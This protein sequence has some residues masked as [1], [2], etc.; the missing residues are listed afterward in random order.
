MASL[1][2]GQSVPGRARK[3]LAALSAATML[4]A[5]CTAGPRSATVSNTRS[6][7]A[8]GS[9]S[10]ATSASTASAAADF[11]LREIDAATLRLL[12]PFPPDG[13]LS[14][15]LEGS[16]GECETRL[17][18]IT[19]PDQP[20]L[21]FVQV[22]ADCDPP[23]A[24]PLNGDYGQFQNVADIPDA[25]IGETFATAIGDAT[26]ATYDYT[27][28]TNSC[29]TGRI[30]VALIEL[31]SPP[32]ENFPVLQVYQPTLRDPNEFFGTLADYVARLE[33]AG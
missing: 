10:A 3:L 4:V 15:V 13:E 26:L 18:S 30:E 7:S 21:R 19:R 32:V 14:E 12:V 33:P 31:T 27:E 5:S 24:R 8:G 28:C 25:D 9:T 2:A 29:T 11:P 6:S 17:T 1:C 20:P 22:A 16:V 23:P